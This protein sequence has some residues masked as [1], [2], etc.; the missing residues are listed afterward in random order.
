[1]VR[2]RLGIELPVGNCFHSV[3]CNIKARTLMGRSGTRA[4]LVHGQIVVI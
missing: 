2:V 3:Y 4:L 1:M